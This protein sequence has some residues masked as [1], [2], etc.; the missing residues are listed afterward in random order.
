MVDAPAVTVTSPRTELE[1]Q[2]LGAGTT[3]T[4]TVTVVLKPEHTDVSEGGRTEVIMVLVLV[5]IAGRDGVM[6]L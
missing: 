2:G 3:V 5:T 4:V 1:A 6:M